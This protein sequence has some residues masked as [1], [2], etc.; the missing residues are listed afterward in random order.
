M[1]YK[2]KNIKPSSVPANLIKEK[3][4]GI[5]IK[6]YIKDQMIGTNKMDLF[7]LVF[8]KGSIRAAAKSMG[9]SEKKAYFLLKTLEDIFPNPILEKKGGNSGTILTPFGK[10][11]LEKYL[12]LNEKL[13]LETQDF[14]HWVKTKKSS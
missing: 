14:I 1:K 6:V 9:M 8:K 3:G 5:K 12:K 11:L 4:N 13:S 10:E 2:S 7:R